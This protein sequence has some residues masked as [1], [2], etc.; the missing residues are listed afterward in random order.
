M[1]STFFHGP[2]MVQ[3]SDQPPSTPRSFWESE[4]LANAVIGGAIRV[5]RALG[6][7]LLESAYEA[8]LAHELTKLGIPTR[9]QVAVPLRYDSIAL[10]VGYRLDLLV[11]EQLILELKCVDRLDR[12]HMAQVMTYLR[13]S[14]VRVGLLINF[15]EAM[16]KNGLRRIVN[17][18]DDPGRV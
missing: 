8:C 9:R 13:L 7:G 16:V 5:H 4:I 10:D 3:P 11:D 1:P 14:G 6:P 2:K 12:V 17:R 15:N 18:Y